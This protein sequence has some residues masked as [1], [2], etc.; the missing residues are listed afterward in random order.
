M[1]MSIL[2]NIFGRSAEFDKDTYVVVSLPIRS[3][4]VFTVEQVLTYMTSN[5]RY[6][7]LDEMMFYNRPMRD[8][9][10]EKG[11]GYVA[12]K[13]LG[14]A[15]DDKDLT[16]EMEKIVRKFEGMQLADFDIQILPITAPLCFY[17]QS[18]TYRELMDCCEV[19][20]RIGRWTSTRE[21]KNEKLH[22]ANVYEPYP[23]F[24]A[25][26]Y[27]SE[28]RDYDNL[29][30]SDSPFTEVDCLEIE[31]FP[32]AY[33][34]RYIVES[35]PAKYLPAVYRDGDSRFMFVATTKKNP[36]ITAKELAK[37]ANQ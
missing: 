36:Q 6:Y 24:D 16:A 11:I 13:L 20:R 34:Y 33:N 21:R 12:D 22:V 31:K 7:E 10:R 23:C 15:P 14:I 8:V 9:I 35:L 29:F 3:Q 19:T 27:A 37:K 2:T 5:K 32:H 25:E 4:T 18:I 17:G 1:T 30:I 28:T 26:D